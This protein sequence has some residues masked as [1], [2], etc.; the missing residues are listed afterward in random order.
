MNTMHLDYS[1]EN[2]TKLINNLIDTKSTEL[3]IEYPNVVG[4][5][6]GEKFI[7]SLN[8]KVPCLTYFVNE[9]YKT[10]NIQSGKIIPDYKYSVPTK[11]VEA[12]EISSY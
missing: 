2:L 12:G 1:S 8:K 6:L 10:E 7:P 5:G 9:K 3:M 11:V 4:I